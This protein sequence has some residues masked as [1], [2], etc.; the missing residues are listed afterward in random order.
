MENET[1]ALTHEQTLAL[2]E[3]I[4]PHLEAIERL[5]KAPRITLLVR[6][7]QLPNGDILL[8]QDDEATIIEAIT[9]QMAK[10]PAVERDADGIDIRH[11]I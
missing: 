7:P 9:R 6:A 8:T 10:R 4:V 5:F 1:P 2:Y 3:K 11:V